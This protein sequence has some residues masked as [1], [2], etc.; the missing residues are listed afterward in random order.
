MGLTGSLL[1]VDDEQDILLFLEMMFQQ[2]SYT[3]YTATNGEDALHLLQQNN[4]DVLVSDIRMPGMTGIEMMEKRFQDQSDLQCIFI[5]GHSD[6][7]MAIEAMKKGALNFL[8][9]PVDF[10]HLEAS[11]QQAME[12]IALLRENQQKKMEIMEYQQNL[13]KLVAKRTAELQLANQ[14]LQKEIE[15]RREAQDAA[16]YQAHHDPLTGL[17]NRLLFRDRMDMA[18]R[19]AQRNNK[20]LALL[21]I[22]LNGLKA[23]NDAFGHV[24]G[25]LLLTEVGQRLKESTRESDTVARMGG[26]EFI[27]ILQEVN[28]FDNAT[29]ISRYV[30]K[31]IEQPFILKGRL[32]S[33]TASIGI[34]LFPDDGAEVDILLRKAEGAMYDEKK[35]GKPDYFYTSFFDGE[36]TEKNSSLPKGAKTD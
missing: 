2:S 5:S 10:E 28:C 3:V 15:V 26:D 11:V 21:L 34:A 20:G 33:I 27:L 18:L 14:K 22:D 24:N 16:L 29:L 25:D 35:K 8:R 4:I 19:L 23:I 31:V 30:C 32:V 12:K 17:A 6:I 13:E 7:D 9:K 36:A 1:I